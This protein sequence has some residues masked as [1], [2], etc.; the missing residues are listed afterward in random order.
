MTNSSWKPLGVVPPTALVDARLVA[1]WASQILGAVGA[2]RVPAEKDFSHT[3][4]GWHEPHQAL[5]THAMGEAKLRAGLSLSTLE[6]LVIEK[7][8]VVSRR[9]L[10]G[11]RSP[12]SLAWL[13]DKL[14]ARLGATV[15][16]KLPEYE[17]PAHDVGDG[18]PFPSPSTAA[19]GELA[20]W[21]HNAHRVVSAVVDKHGVAASPARCW[22]HHFDLATLIT[23]VAHEDP[24]QAQTIGVGLSPGDAGYAQPYWYATPWPRPADTALRDLPVGQWHTTGWT[25]AVL[26]G[27][28]LVSQDGQQ[29]H[30]QTFVDG[31]L[32]ALLGVQERNPIHKS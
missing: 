25:G 28:D 8:E 17:M 14:D 6:L 30:T 13:Q 21:F 15:A 27:A 9:A 4:L 29:K 32:A 16:L 31:A 24:E 19:L 22:P 18:T 7:E 1:H 2:S 5:V 12:E 10:A 26:T 3:S 20:S 23:I 11:T